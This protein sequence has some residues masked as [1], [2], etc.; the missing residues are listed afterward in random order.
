V[1]LE[2]L[3][4]DTDQRVVV[5][6]PSADFV[7]LGRAR[8]GV[9]PQEAARATRPPVRVL[10]SDRARHGEGEEPLRMRFRTMPRATQAAVLCLDP[11]SDHEEYNA[12]VRFLDHIEEAELG[13]V[14]RGLCD[15]LVLRRMNSPA[16]VAEL[17]AVF[18]YVPPQTLAASTG[19]LQ[20]EMLLAGP[21]VPVPT[22]ARVRERL[23]VEGGGDVAVPLVPPGG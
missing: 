5:L 22:L 14:F 6:D 20:G 17:S 9:D 3:L 21:M 18:G 2:R 10:R 11:V 15:N 19:F 23:T 1:L 12:C 8:P 7:Q 13:D 4:I 16:D